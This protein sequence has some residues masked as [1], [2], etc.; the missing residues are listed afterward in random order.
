MFK[1][2][3]ELCY[4]CMRHSTACSTLQRSVVRPPSPQGRGRTGPVP[5]PCMILLPRGLSWSRESGP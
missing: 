1:Q 2:P 5:L 3:Y 4:R